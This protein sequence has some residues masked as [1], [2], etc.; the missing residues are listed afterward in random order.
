[1][2]LTDIEA[3]ELDH[4]YPD[5]DDVNYLYR[6]MRYD[7]NKT[8]HIEDLL[9][10]RNLYHASPNQFNDP[11]ECKPHFRL[12]E[13]SEK[14]NVIALR[15]YEISLKYGMNKEDAHR[16]SSNYIDNPNLLRSVISQSAKDTY[17]NLKICCFTTSNQ[18]TLLW[19]HYADSHRGFCLEFDAKI[20]PISSAHRV[21]YCD[22]YPTITFPMPSNI[23]SFIPALVKSNAWSYEQEYRKVLLSNTEN[24]K[25]LT[26]IPPEALKAIFFGANMTDSN[27]EF[28]I[29]IIKKGPFKPKLWKA[30]L[31]ESSFSIHFNE[32]QLSP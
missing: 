17:G 27:V 32:L 26:T 31:S 4:P 24:Y 23:T 5:Y 1:M 11:F 25:Q 7:P 12:P 13:S 22:A 3:F 8:S 30:E 9:I 19:S 10:N 18:N 29:K 16:I 14:L 20:F 21:K 15:L 28:L 6:Y 2:R